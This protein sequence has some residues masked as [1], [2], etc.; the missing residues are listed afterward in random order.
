MSHFT[1]C[2]LEILA[3]VNREREGDTAITRALAEY[4]ALLADMEALEPVRISVVR[5]P[6]ATDAASP[7]GPVRKWGVK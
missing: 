2:D 6:R 3:A 4:R 7:F 5:E 1:A